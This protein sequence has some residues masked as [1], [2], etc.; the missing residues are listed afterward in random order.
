M[1]CGV[2]VGFSIRLP[3]NLPLT[4]AETLRATCVS[5]VSALNTEAP[6]KLPLT[7]PP[8]IQESL[9]HLGTADREEI[10]AEVKQASL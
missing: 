6:P 1:K 3:P 2:V 8:S 7:K 5:L 9:R 4:N 10:Q